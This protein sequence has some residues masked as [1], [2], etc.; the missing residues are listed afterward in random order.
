MLYRENKTMEMIGHQCF[1]HLLSKDYGIAKE[2]FGNLL[3][4][5]DNQV[6]YDLVEV[7]ANGFMLGY[8][9]GK[10]AERARRKKMHQDVDGF[11]AV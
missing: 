6:E 10:R 2:D 7:T 9:Y 8:I 3:D 4:A 11:S 1:L 5:Y